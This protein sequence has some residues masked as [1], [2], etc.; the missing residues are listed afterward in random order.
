MH[1][2]LQELRNRLQENHGNCVEALT[3]KAAADTDSAATVNPDTPNVL[4]AVMKLEQAKARAKTAN[5]VAL[6]AEKEKDAAEKSVEELKRQIQPK[7]TRTDDDAADAHE[8]LAEVV[9]KSALM[10]E[11]TR[12]VSAAAGTGVSG[13]SIQ[14]QATAAVVTV[15][16]DAR[17]PGDEQPR[18]KCCDVSEE[19][20]ERRQAQVQDEKFWAWQQGTDLTLVLKGRRGLKHFI[21][22]LKHIITPTKL[23]ARPGVVSVTI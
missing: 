17:A 15:L 13:A 18:R 1:A 21:V 5:K 19:E 22:E 4:H 11:N 9:T 10:A 3:K 23:L 2:C 7:R 8:T 16:R 20:F 12:C 6:E 14:E